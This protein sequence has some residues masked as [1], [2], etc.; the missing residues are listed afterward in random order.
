MDESLAQED[1]SEDYLPVR[2]VDGTPGAD[3]PLERALDPCIETRVV[4]QHL[5]EDRHCPD[6]RSRLEDRHDL[7]L[8]NINERVG[9]TP[10]A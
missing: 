7:A 5:L 2:P 3:A 6:A 1:L 9:P 4:R 10:A 8:K